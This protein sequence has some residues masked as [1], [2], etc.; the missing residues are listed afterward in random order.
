VQE[1]EIYNILASLFHD[2]FDDDSIVLQSGT[3]ASNID[4]WDSFNH[5]NLI[6]ATE[7]AFKVKFSTKE[8]E[9]MSRVGDFVSLIQE[10]L[11][12]QNDSIPNQG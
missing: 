11:T 6:V 10:K 1:A 8:I 4:G 9:S 12:F 2:L 3:N 7:A 5:I